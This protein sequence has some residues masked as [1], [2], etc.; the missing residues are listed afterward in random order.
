MG[1]GASLGAKMHAETKDAVKD[2]EAKSDRGG[3]PALEEGGWEQAKKGSSPGTQ[4]GGYGEVLR[5][6][7]N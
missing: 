6:L 5:S 2:G 7:C 4:E 3:T 1:G